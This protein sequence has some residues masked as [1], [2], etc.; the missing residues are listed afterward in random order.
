MIALI[1]GGSACGK[2]TYAERLACAL[3][4]ENRIYV[5]TM[6]VCDEESVQRVKRHRAQ[7]AGKGFQ[8]FEI[9]RQLGAI[10]FENDST[11]LLEDMVN[12]LANE[13]F[14]G[15]N[16]SRIEKDI[17]NL[18]RRSRHLVIVT[19]D[20]FSDGV[21]YAEPTREYARNL[22]YLNRCAAEMADCV[23]ELVYSIPLY[24][25]GEQLCLS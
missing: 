17:E 3:P 14:S 6:Q 18:A 16:W 25:K 21:T 5:A 22:A 2:S 7:R 8:T 20:V 1:T 19:N 15:G 10:S 13:M 23:V 12:L 24:V 11:V 9:P 4:A